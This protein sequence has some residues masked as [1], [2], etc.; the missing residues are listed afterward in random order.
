MMEEDHEARIAVLETQMEIMEE[1]RDDVKILV[2]KLNQGKGVYAFA[3]VAA[4]A[5]GGVIA[6][7]ISYLTR[8]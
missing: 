5:V 4:S 8:H 6:T 1:V 2:A 7:G 3:V